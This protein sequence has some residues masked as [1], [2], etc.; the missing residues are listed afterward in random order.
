[1]RLF[2]EEEDGR[3][4]EIGAPVPAQSRTQTKMVIAS[5]SH[6][7]HFFFSATW[8]K[9]RKSFSLNSSTE[10]K[11]RQYRFISFPLLSFIHC[12]FSLFHSFKAIFPPVNTAKNP[13]LKSTPCSVTGPANGPAAKR[14]VSTWRPSSSTWPPNTSWTTRARL[15]PESKCRSF[16]SSNCSWTR[17]ANDSKPWWPTCTW[18]RRPT[19]RGT[20]VLLRPWPNHLL[21]RLRIIFIMIRHLREIRPS[22]R[23]LPPPPAITSSSDPNHHP[24][25]WPARNCR[26]FHLRIQP[27]DCITRCITR[28]AVF[29][30]WAASRTVWP[31][32]CTKRPFRPWPRRPD[33]RRCPPCN[34]NNNNKL[35]RSRAAT[36]TTIP[37]QAWEVRFAEGSLTKRRCRLLTVR[38]TQF[39]HANGRVLIGFS[40]QE[41]PT[42]WTEPAWISRKVRNW[43]ALSYTR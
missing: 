2:E 4:M 29:R 34:N 19:W 1:M 18:P 38:R 3:K 13:L 8:I 15:R 40:F 42:W 5:L 28:P 20:K 11:F 9:A 14:I 16:R 39:N 32:I 31:R 37:I 17:N 12:P 35:R 10:K 25:S 22:T 33:H 7:I 36:A 27:A 6:S 41:C 26:N 23:L 21:F 30:P 43:E 24:R